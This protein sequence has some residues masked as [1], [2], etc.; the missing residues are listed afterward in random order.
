MRK[1]KLLTD[2]QKLC[3]E[4]G[5]KQA[6]SGGKCHACNKRQWRANNPIKAAYNNLKSN[7]KR[8]GKKFEISFEYFKKFVTKNDYM[9]KKGRSATSY[10]IDRIDEGK[11]YIEGN[12]R[13]L[14]NRGNYTKY[15]VN[16][17][18]TKKGR[19]I[20][21][22]VTQRLDTD[23]EI[24]QFWDDISQGKFEKYGLQDDKETKK[25]ETDFFDAATED[26]ISG[27]DD[28]PF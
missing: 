15:L 17:Y 5:K 13:I 9:T 23:E 11:G 25:D 1:I 7:A 12:L 19:L 16:H 20:W 26:D 27:V 6:A 21:F 28:P 18:D 2:R 4:C 14:T 8:R 22:Y 24:A 3:K 10:H